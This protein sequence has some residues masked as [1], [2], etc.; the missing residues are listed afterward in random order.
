MKITLEF[1]LKDIEFVREVSDNEIK[2]ALVEYLKECTDVRMAVDQT[3]IP[4]IWVDTTDGEE[5]FNVYE[6]I[7]KDQ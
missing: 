1:E 3:D 5:Q 4:A 2:Y 6:I 7:L